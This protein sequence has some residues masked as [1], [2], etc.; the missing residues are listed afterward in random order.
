MKIKFNLILLFGLLALGKLDAQILSSA[1]FIKG[2]KN[3]ALKIISAYLL[4]VERS[5]C[6]NGANNNML[7]FKQKDKTDYRFGIGLDLTTSFVNSD[8][9]TYN[10]NNL[11]L[12]EFEPANPQ[13][14][15]AQTIAGN[16]NT[17]VLQTKA[18]YLIL[19]TAYPFY[20]QKSI[21]KLNS[22]QGNNNTAIPFPLLHLFAEK[23]G[24]LIDLKILPSFNIEN[25]TIGVFNVGLNIQ[26]NLKTSLQFLSEMWFDVY[27]SGGYNINRVIYYLDIKP[28][29]QAFTFSINSDKG[30]YDNQEFRIY[31]QSIPIR[32]SLVKQ[33]HDFSFSLGSAYNITN[34]QVEM[35]GK[36][37]VFKADPTNTFQII[38]TDISGPFQY[39][40]NFNK[41]SLEA[42]VNYQTQQFSAGLKYAYSYYKNIDFSFGYFF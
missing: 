12:E 13:Q 3:D 14:I 19:S 32:L 30:P 38:A 33:L 41:I 16:Q 1:N 22:P 11:N 29:E 25:S 21:L 40:R 5:L 18:K 27:L 23:Q 6:F 9:F 24:N 28:D 36:Y 42:G 34:S 10:V 2:G 26:H 31:T 15:S 7:I 17:I 37:P 8:D 39:T 20:E 35:L 4:P